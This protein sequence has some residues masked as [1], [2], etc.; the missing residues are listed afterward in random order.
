[1][2][3]I[4]SSLLLLA[5]FVFPAVAQQG[6]G[7][8]KGQHGEGQHGPGHN[9]IASLEKRI[10]SLVDE[11][12]SMIRRIEQ[13]NR[14]TRELKRKQSQ[15]G[16]NRSAE[17]QLQ[18][19][20]TNR[21]NSSDR[22]RVSQLDLEIDR[23]RVEID[24]LMHYRHRDPVIVQKLNNQILSLVAANEK[25]NQNLLKRNTELFQARKARLL[26]EG[27]ESDAAKRQVDS[28]VLANQLDTNTIEMNNVA[29]ERTQLKIDSIL[30]G[31]YLHEHNHG[32]GKR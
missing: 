31:E 5:L 6:K 22:L 3:F 2:K 1:M 23:T 15:A 12:E 24:K 28:L 18:V 29:I 19:L 17:L 13:R 25:L 30:R 26:N 10:A 16:Q 4:L 7:K 11:K 21:D 8:G 27:N 20:I 14:T 9:S 32:G